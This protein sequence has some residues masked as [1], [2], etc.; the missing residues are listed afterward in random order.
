MLLSLFFKDGRTRETAPRISLVSNR[1]LGRQ[2]NI[3]PSSGADTHDPSG[4]DAFD[5]EVRFKPDLD[6]AS[7]QRDVP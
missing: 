7:A 1:L 3:A 2:K 4:A 6:A 5:D